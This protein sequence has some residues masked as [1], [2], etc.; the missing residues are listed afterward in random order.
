MLLLRA[1]VGSPDAPGET[2]SPLDRLLY[3][4]HV[5]FSPDGWRLAT[6]GANGDVPIWDSRS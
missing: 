6:G 2:T 3:A 1:S 4:C 5:R